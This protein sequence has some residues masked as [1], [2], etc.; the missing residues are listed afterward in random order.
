[1]SGKHTAIDIA[2]LNNLR[3]STT[4]YLTIDCFGVKIYF[5]LQNDW[6]EIVEAINDVYEE[7]GGCDADTG[8]LYGVTVARKKKGED[9]LHIFI[10]VEP[11]CS[12]LRV[13]AHEIYH[14]VDMIVSY[15]R[16]EASSEVGASISEW[17]F[18]EL[19]GPLVKVTS[20]YLVE[21]NE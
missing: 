21:D 5:Y 8:R 14:A 11:S 17:L 16:A 3:A 6:G 20:D 7:Q 10:L 13:I 1:M 19:I 2:K 18:G 9:S 4:K 15:V 12:M